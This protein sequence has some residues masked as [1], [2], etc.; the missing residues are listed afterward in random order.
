MRLESLTG[1]SREDA[2]TRLASFL[3]ADEDTAMREFFETR[4]TGEKA[5]EDRWSRDLDE[6]RMAQVQ[7]LY[8]T[9]L[10]GLLDAGAG[11]PK[12]D[13]EEVPGEVE[14]MPTAAAT[15]S[16]G[17]V[18]PPS[19]TPHRPATSEQ[20]SQVAP[21]R[22]T[23]RE[24][25]ER[26]AR[27]HNLFDGSLRNFRT[28]TLID[29]GA[30]HGEH[31]RRAAD[32]G[33][34][35]T[36]VDARDERFPNDDR[37]TWVRQDVR[38]VD[39]AGYD[40]IL[41]LGLFYHLTL[42]DQ[43][44]LLKRT[45]GTPLILDTHVAT[46]QPTHQ[47]SDPIEDRGYHGRYYSETGWQ[48][49]ATASWNNT[50]SFWPT[51]ETLYRMLADHGYPAVFAGTPWV[52][53]DRTFF[54]C[55]PDGTSSPADHGT[56]DS[57]RATYTVNRMTQTSDQEAE[58][59]FVRQGWQFVDTIE[60]LGSKES[61][62]QF[63]TI[64][65]AERARA[66][67]AFQPLT[68]GNLCTTKHKRIYEGESNLTR[69][70]RTRDYVT[71]GERVFD[72]GLGR[73]YLPGILLRDGE[74]GAY[75]GIDPDT[76]NVKATRQMFELNGLADRG[77]AAVGDLYELTRKEVAQFGADLVVCCEVIEHVPD[78]EKAVQALANALPEGAELLISVPLLGELE[79]VWGHVNF[80][81]M[82][83]ARAMVEH[84]GLTVHH[85]D[86][87]D[88]IWTFILASNDPK[89]SPRA[90]RAAAAP[91]DVTANARGTPD[92]P[93]GFHHLDLANA[94]VGPSSW[95]IRLASS[96]VA[97]V[98]NGVEFEGVAEDVGRI[99]KGRTVNSYTGISL[100]IHDTDGLRI[101]LEV[102]AAENVKAIYIDFN[103]DGE[104][105]GRWKWD[106][107]RV[108]IEPSTKTH[109][110]RPGRR[111]PTFQRHLAHDLPS[112]TSAEI[113]AQLEPGGSVKIRLNRAAK[114][115]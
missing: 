66:R 47:L 93:R 13:L 56:A 87:V 50:Q 4:V 115:R 43:L 36:A 74:L 15:R 84:A 34:Q 22:P 14:L 29:L 77:T 40:L 31:S 30:G 28:G 35:V 100:P 55:V 69:F 104:R 10:Q 2:Y 95:Q 59:A 108:A 73:G 83:R 51:P 58:R 42:D 54:L 65:D 5:H 82:A 46:D 20:T 98:N 61:R 38:E 80:F 9:H 7:E 78:A 21:P 6:E 41:C 86:A 23:K 17:E 53:T 111:S 19:A 113:F 12:P 44:D 106:S 37:I 94:G 89:P 105:V 49:R 90:A 88:N 76:T 33:W 114:I 92:M 52:T 1:E 63:R 96:N 24:R 27:R 62:K 11:L 8:A 97:V 91:V 68:T 57:E 26:S 3:A 32:A 48:T 18:Q 45:S 99:R 16:T 72:I 67:D 110:L 112:A 64:W 75:H 102:V 107:E 109:V 70:R 103:A 39:L 85:V 25:Q 60:R 79:V 101:E 71:P 81:D